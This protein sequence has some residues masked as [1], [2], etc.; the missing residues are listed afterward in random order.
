MKIAALLIGCLIAGTVAADTTKHEMWSWKDSEGVT[1]YSD[2]P[3]P[4]AKRIE[5][6]T[7]T[8]QSTPP[9]ATPASEP[10]TRPPAPT[11]IGYNEIEIYTP[12]NEE[13]FYGLDSEV[14]VRVRSDPGLKP[15]DQVR[16]YLDSNPVEKDPTSLVVTLSNLERGAHSVTAQIVDEFGKPLALSESRVFYIK[17]PG[18]NKSPN[19]GPA[20]KPKPPPKPKPVGGPKSNP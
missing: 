8:P 11:I 20:L 19:V 4:G 15:G 10:G 9:P 18:V 7:M 5:I 1:H 6:A 2:V 3:V 17:Q 12:E 13:S 14:T 16:V